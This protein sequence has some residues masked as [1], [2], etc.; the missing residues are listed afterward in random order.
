[1][2]ATAQAGLSSASTELIQRTLEIWYAGGP[3]MYAIAGVAILMCG[4][5]VNVL[6]ALTF[7][8]MRPRRD[9]TV[10][11]WIESPESADEGG[12]PALAR[13]AATASDGAAI[14]PL[15][16]EYASRRLEP[17]ENQLRVMKVCVSAAPLLG[18]FGTVTGMLA[19]FDALASGTGG[20]QTMGAIAKGIAEALITTEAGLA[21]ALPGV[22]FHYFMSQ[23][24]EA[25]VDFLGHVQSACSEAATSARP[26]EG[27]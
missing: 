1:M 24:L 23:R 2:D 10:R 3:S 6:L 14:E 17:L 26:G 8:D 18:L 20:E 12:L 21:V 27:G 7:G 19:T 16:D 9:A 25:S 11:E 22:F 13:A 4:V 15:F 5:G